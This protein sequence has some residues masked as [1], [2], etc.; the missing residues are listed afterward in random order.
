MTRDQKSQVIAELTDK[1]KENQYFYITDTSGL[2][3]AEINRF[4]QLCYNQGVQYKVFKNTLIRKALENVEADVETIN[5]ALKGTSGVMFINENGNVPAKIIKNFKKEISKDKPRFKAASIDSDI[6]IGEDQLEM[7]TKLKS[8]QE[9]IGE[10]IT[11]L[12]SP[13]TNVISALQSGSHKLAGIVK[14]LS[15]RE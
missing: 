8:K 12:Q 6:F 13:A 5:Q 9:L 11:L 10:I 15:E 7:L 2:T 4:R 14:T 1:L 3:V